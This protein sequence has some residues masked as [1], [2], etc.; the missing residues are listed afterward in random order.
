[1]K[2]LQDK[3]KVSELVKQEN[4]E[5]YFETR[6]LGFVIYQYE[7]GEI[8][9]SPD[10]P[11][12]SILY[13]VEGIVQIYGILS[14]GGKLSVRLMSKPTLLGDVEFCGNMESPL[15]TEAMTD[16][17]C[18]ALPFDANRNI[19]NRDVR[20][21]H[22]LL[23]SLTRK[24][25]SNSKLEVEMPTVEERVLFYMENVFDNHGLVVL[26]RQWPNCDAAEGSFKE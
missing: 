18:L 3:R 21:L 1:M 22:V 11:L 10:R 23:R 8:I 7:K 5:K 4:V 19:L 24:M 9:A 25:V 26:K 20:F 2:V 17:T 16:V 13:L 6:E 14:D 15:F 12:R